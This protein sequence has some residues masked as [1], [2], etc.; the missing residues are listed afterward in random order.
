MNCNY[1]DYSC[2]YGVRSVYDRLV[3]ENDKLVSFNRNIVVSVHDNL[4]VKKSLKLE[5]KAFKKLVGGKYRLSDGGDNVKLVLKAKPS[6]NFN[7]IGID[8]NDGYENIKSSY[9]SLGFSCK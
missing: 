8:V 2:I 6:S 3:F 1:V 5:G 7:Y 9:S 4:N